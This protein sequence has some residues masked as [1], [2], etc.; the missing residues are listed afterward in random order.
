MP[1]NDYRRLNVDPG[2]LSVLELFDEWVRIKAVN[3]VPQVGKLWLDS[4]Y[5]TWK[6]IQ[7][8]VRADAH[9]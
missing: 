5:P 4:F 1:F 7:K 2:A 8:L 6:Q 9:T 3:F